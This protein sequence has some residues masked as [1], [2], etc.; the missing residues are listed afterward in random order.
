MSA[1]LPPSPG[2]CNFRSMGCTMSKNLCAKA[3]SGNEQQNSTEVNLRPWILLRLS[4]G[5]MHDFSPTFFFFFSSVKVIQVFKNRHHLIK[6]HLQSKR[7]VIILCFLASNLISMVYFSQIYDKSKSSHIKGLLNVFPNTYQIKF[8]QPSHKMVINI[9]RKKCIKK[10]EWL[11]KQTLKSEIE[12][13]HV[14]RRQRDSK[15]IIHYIVGK[16]LFNIKKKPHN[17]NQVIR[18]LMS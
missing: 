13:I 9:P 11:N 17:P 1:V 6:S 15:E 3:A 14:D 10:I 5:F 18:A 12:K 16:G 7:P 4:L 8:S 2:S